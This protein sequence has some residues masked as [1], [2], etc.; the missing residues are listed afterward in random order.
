M[1]FFEGDAIV[2]GEAASAPRCH[3]RRGALPAAPKW[4]R[5]RTRRMLRGATHSHYT[6]AATRI[7]GQRRTVT[8]RAVSEHAG[9][10]LKAFVLA[11]RVGPLRLMPRTPVQK[12]FPPIPKMPFLIF[13]PSNS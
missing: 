13:F 7:R 8:V 2:L 1:H 4:P 9:P 3:Y 6:G 5:S 10:S 11:A 12:T